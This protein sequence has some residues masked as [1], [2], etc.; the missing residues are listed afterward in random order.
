MFYKILYIVMIFNIIVK[1]DTYFIFCLRNVMRVNSLTVRLIINMACWCVIFIDDLSFLFACDHKN[2][3]IW[4]D[5][6][7][8]LIDV[9]W[10]RICY[11]KYEKVDFYPSKSLKW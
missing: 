9:D 3:E 11:C 10:V 4:Y 1:F 8:F 5:E 2:K 7:I 6:V